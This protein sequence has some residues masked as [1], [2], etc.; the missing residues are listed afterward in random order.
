MAALEPYSFQF[1]AHELPHRL[2]QLSAD[3]LTGYWL[4]EF[5][6]KQKPQPMEPWYLGISH[7]RIVFSGNQKICWREF[8]KTLQRYVA[9]LNHSDVK[10]ILSTLEQ[11]FVQAEQ[12]AQSNL[13]LALLQKLYQL[14]LINPEE[15]EQAFQL[16]IL[17][18]FDNYLLQYSGEARFLPFAQL[19]I[20]AP[21]LGFSIQDLLLKAKERQ[22]WW[23]K[24]QTVVPMDSVPALNRESSNASQ[25]THEQ[26]QRLEM[27]VANG[28]TIHE[29][30]CSLAQDSLEVAIFFANLVKEELVTL[31]PISQTVNPEIFIIDDSPLMLKQFEGLVTSWGYAVRSF[32][33]PTVALQALSSSRPIAIFLD[34]NMPGIT[35]FD[36][37]KQI[38]RQPELASVPLVMLTAEKTLSNNWRARWSGCRFLSKP[39]TPPEITQFYTELRLL[40][41]ELV[42]LT[43]SPDL[44]VNCAH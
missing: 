31:T 36:L 41:T 6:N 16:K 20:Q 22:L 32:S 1:Q 15:L 37:V 39:L 7:G 25:L 29:I 17:S 10:H 21:I 3:Y 9:R 42:P 13:F 19:E 14:N 18:D 2:S 27:L 33:D 8:L 44:E 43:S 11:Q 4:F 38:R 12:G 5:T 24:L 34:I 35:G 23:Q 40:L 30:A 26:K 28:K